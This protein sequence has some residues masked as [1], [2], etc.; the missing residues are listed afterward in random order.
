MPQQGS[1]GTLKH[2]SIINIATHMDSLW[3]ADYIQNY[4]DQYNFMY[5]I[6]P[7]DVLPAHLIQELIELLVQKRQLSRR[8]L[9]LMIHQHLESLHLGK[10]SSCM[11]DAIIKLV[12]IRCKKL[13]KLDISRCNRLTSYAMSMA[14]SYLPKLVYLN[15]YTTNCTDDVLGTIGA[16]C[17][18]LRDLNICKTNVTEKGIVSLCGGGNNIQGCKK[19]VSLDMSF[20]PRVTIKGV[21]HALRQLPNLRQLLHNDVCDALVALH[22]EAF[23][24][25]KATTPYQIRS[26]T[27]NDFVVPVSFL[28]IVDLVCPNL[29][30]IFIL[31]EN[32]EGDVLQ[33]IS[34]LTRLRNLSVSCTDSLVPFSEGLVFLLESV[35]HGLET[36]TLYGYDDIDVI[37]IGQFCPN[38]Q[39]L[40]LESCHGFK[41]QRAQSATLTALFSNLKSL[42]LGVEVISNDHETTL[43]KTLKIVLEGSHQ[44]ENIEITNVE[45]FTDQL[46]RHVLNHNSFSRLREFA[47]IDCNNIT[48]S[49][50]F[51]LLEGKNCLQRLVLLNCK[52]V[53]R[54]DYDQMM[55][56]VANQHFQLEITWT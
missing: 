51:E 30:Y 2:L 42:R 9:H 4:L 40:T 33:H 55:K 43:P 24:E 1:P 27:V 19:L 38:L 44:I 18:H 8:H 25:G 20:N 23:K 35:G 45:G 48:G 41:L 13:K 52:E 14:L 16:I 46:F 3:A 53:M 7:F 32:L 49:S 29:E 22:E 31:N 47:L 6:G 17:V 15:L 28:E 50:M 36:L 10:C 34:K 54:R 5:I 26:G 39:T 56:I 11:T 12:Q 21:K 37:A